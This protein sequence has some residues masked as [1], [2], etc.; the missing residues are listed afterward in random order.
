MNEDVLPIE[1]GDFPMSCQFSGVYS[2]RKEMKGICWICFIF[3]TKTVGKV[4]C[5]LLTLSFQ[6]ALK[7]ECMYVWLWIRT[8]FFI[9]L[10][11]SIFHGMFRNTCHFCQL[12]TYPGASHSCQL[13]CSIELLRD[14]QLLAHRSALAAGCQRPEKPDPAFQCFSY[15]AID[16]K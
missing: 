4:W 15:I 7:R 13:R 6:M 12:K 14:G 11:G 8:F 2:L 3:I 10:Y 9:Q 16:R 5:A 1:K